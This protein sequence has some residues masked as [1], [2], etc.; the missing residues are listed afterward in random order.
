[1]ID[2]DIAIVSKDLAFQDGALFCV[3]EDIL[4]DRGGIC[5]SLA[6]LA[7]IRDIHPDAHSVSCVSCFE[8]FD[9][10]GSSSSFGHDFFVNEASSEHHY[11]HNGHKNGY[12]SVENKAHVRRYGVDAVK[13]IKIWK[14]EP[15]NEAK[16]P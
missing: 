1:M 15:K 9:N 5:M 13:I 7:F 16:H 3:I 11:A 10:T 14:D 2:I 4:V 12:D 8:A 6:I